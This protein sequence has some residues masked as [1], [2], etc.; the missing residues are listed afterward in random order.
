[1]LFLTATPF[2]LGHN[3][4]V[5]IL[6]RFEGIRWRPDEDLIAYRRRVDEV[7]HRLGR[8]QVE[9]LAL[10]QTWGRIRAEDLDGPRGRTWWLD[11]TAAPCPSGCSAPPR[12]S[13]GPARRS[14]PPR[15]C[16]DP[17]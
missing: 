8:A 13:S 12:R 16:C 10:D 9:G 1:M 11:E 2:Q 3:E 15:R 4:L 14:A 17:G 6:R 5:Q 7:D